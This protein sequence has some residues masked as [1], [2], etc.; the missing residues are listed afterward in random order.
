M[1][2]GRDCAAGP[3]PRWRG[4]A[5]APAG[6]R[7]ASGA[8]RRDAP[9]RQLRQ[10]TGH[11]RAELRAD[12]LAIAAAALAAVDP[13]ARLRAQLRLDGDRLVVDPRGR[14]APH[15]DLRGR[16]VFV[17]GAGKATIGMAPCSTSCSATASRPAPSS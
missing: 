5:D 11:G 6:A 7:P 16:R 17:V 8:A 4:E 10:L 9:L 12:A 3:R 1:Y 14:R 13:A 15:F 2:A